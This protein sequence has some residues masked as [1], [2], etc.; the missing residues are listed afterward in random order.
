MPAPRAWGAAL[1]AFGA[2][3]LV[4]L[5]L[6]HGTVASLLR[7][8]SH[9][10]T[11]AHG[12]LVAPVS[13]FLVWRSRATLAA[14][15]PR[16]EFRALV[17]LI[18]L[19]AGWFVG[20]A[21]STQL[22]EHFC[23][24]AMIPVLA[25]AHFGARVTRRLAFPLAF[26]FFAVPFG[27]IFT[28][29]LMDVTAGFAE[30][31]L[32]L[33]GVAVHREGLYLTTTHSRWHVIESCSGLRFT[34]AGLVLATLF[35][36]LTYRSYW[37]RA[38]FV[39]LSVAASVLAN[40]L[41]AYVLILVGHLSDMRAGGGLDHYA[42]GWLVFSLVMAAFFIVGGR[43]RDLWPAE[44]P[45]PAPPSDGGPPVPRARWAAVAGA[46]L[47]LV[48]V[49][50]ALERAR[51]ASRVSATSAALAAPAEGG[52]WT[53]QPEAPFPWKPGFVGAVAE[54][55]GMY[56]GE[57]GAVQCYVAYYAHQT[58]GRELLHAGNQVVDPDDPQARVVSMATRAI[59]EGGAGFAAREA[60]VEAPA[61]NVVLWYWYWVPDEFT[62]NPLRVKWL[63]ARDAVL[64]RPDHAAAVVLAASAPDARDAE[65]LLAR[66]VR[67]MLPSIRASLRSAHH[68][69]PSRR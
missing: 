69:P 16:P 45:P 59:P 64:G 48:A 27:D 1:T 43:F 63:E 55:D 32:R 24:V 52:E 2:T 39:A 36:Y 62:A 21:A 46:A 26:L 58:Q 10:D 17:A 19:G 15:T 33:T 11:F 66:F 53:L 38:L 29:R 7:V 41:R 22:V 57:S 9:S 34:V 6:G 28:P 44:T 50:P 3:L 60:V 47:L 61:G 56:S 4:T 13:L 67:D 5:L 23:F 49:W 20:R 54:T 31:A 25:W 65:R 37:K 68:A 35:G 51:A 14:L 40:G 30:R 42:Y 8:W 12:F 18:P